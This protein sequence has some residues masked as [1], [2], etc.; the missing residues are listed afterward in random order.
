MIVAEQL[1][2][3]QISENFSK[4]NKTLFHLILFFF[5]EIFSV[6]FDMTAENIISGTFVKIKR[7]IY[8]MNYC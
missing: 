3:T 4:K 7:Q 6:L 2:F 1:I 8:E 5:N